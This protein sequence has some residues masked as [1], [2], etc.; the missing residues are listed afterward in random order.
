M[1]DRRGL[2]AGGA[3]LALVGTGKAAPRLPRS[4]TDTLT[5]RMAEDK[6][7]GAA[8]SV[9]RGG[10][11]VAFWAHGLASIP[12]DVP[13]RQDTLF[14]IGSVAKHVTALAVLQLMEAGRVALDDPIGRHVKDLPQH[15][16]RISIRNLLHQTSG[17]PDYVDFLSDWDRRQPRNVVTFALGMMP[18][19]F[20]PGEAWHYSNT[21][22][23]V[24]GWLIEDV[25]GQSY[26]DYVRLRL[27]APARLPEARA[28]AAQH[29]VANRAEPYDA[30][31]GEVRHAVRMADDVSAAAD[32]G[33]LFSAR[34]WA[35]W[36]RALAA[37]GLV[38]QGSL[39]AM[40]TPAILSTG[41]EVPYGYGWFLGKTRGAPYHWHSGSVPG[42]VTQVTRLPA[43]DLLAVLTINST[44]GDGT[45][46]DVPMMA[47]EAIAPGST[48]LSLPDGPEATE[49]RRSRLV[50]MLTGGGRDADWIAPELAREFRA[51]APHDPPAI[52]SP[53]AGI[54][55]VESYPAVG[56][57]ME[58]YR[59]S[60]GNRDRYVLAGWTS[61]GQLF[62]IA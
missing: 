30:T 45:L 51:V 12:F 7:V 24:L 3:A 53:I 41:R 43:R 14:Q 9:V 22:Y 61:D 6:V 39:D 17:L 35:P 48:Y 8:L 21:N 32:G 33:L 5:A 20:A 46:A 26:A 28:D 54:R 13:V 36:S 52:Y 31:E 37:P 15:W 25:S 55:L 2:I 19:L 1:F 29:P 27:F 59:V 62:I 16:R 57:T 56:G 60:A 44:T 4:L 10:A 42:F 38:S 18:L 23:L 11:I 49:P 47:M 58:R 50:A 40:F 34:D